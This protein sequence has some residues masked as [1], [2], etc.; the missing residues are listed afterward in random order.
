[1]EFRKMCFLIYGYV[2]N[3]AYD[4]SVFYSKTAK[5]YLICDACSW[6]YPTGRVNNKL[7]G[8]MAIAH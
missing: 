4:I 6:N 5:L 3:D 7:S 2:V 1:M 8:S